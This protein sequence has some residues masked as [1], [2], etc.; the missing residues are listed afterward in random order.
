[1]KRMVLEANRLATFN[2]DPMAQRGEELD[3]RRGA[4]AGRLVESRVA[5]VLVASGDDELG[6]GKRG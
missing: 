6:V 1:M 4:N 2:R 3:D 5:G